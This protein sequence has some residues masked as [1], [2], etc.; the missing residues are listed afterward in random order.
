[1]KTTFFRRPCHLSTHRG[2][3]CMRGWTLIMISGLYFLR[4]ASTFLQFWSQHIKQIRSMVILTV[5]WSR[6]KINKFE[7][8]SKKTKF[9]DHNSHTLKFK[10]IKDWWDYS[11]EKFKYFKAQH[12]LEFRNVSWE[13]WGLVKAMYWH[14]KIEHS[15]II[16]K[17]NK[18]KYHFI[19]KR[20]YVENKWNQHHRVSL[21]SLTKQSQQDRKGACQLE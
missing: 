14:L 12:D 9:S 19:L 15:N 20:I 8:V 17:I 10:C 18:T 11:A 6:G 7:N 16:L 2:M 3:C 1:M 4:P 13:D 5:L 21:S